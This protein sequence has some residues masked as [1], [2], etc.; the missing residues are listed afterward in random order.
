M[1]ADSK[2]IGAAFGAF[3]LSSL[4]AL[5]CQ[6]RVAGRQQSRRV[7]RATVRRRQYCGQM[8]QTCCCRSAAAG[9]RLLM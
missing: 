9:A 6:W 8:Q 2:A 5:P 4:P 3:W 7:M 1:A